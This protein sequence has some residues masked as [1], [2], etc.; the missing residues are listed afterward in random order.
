MM[1]NS[2]IQMI[3]ELSLRLMSIAID[4]CCRMVPAPRNAGVTTA[5]VEQ[6]TEHVLRTADRIA[7]MESGLVRCK[8]S[9]A[10]AARDGA[11]MDACLGA[12]E[13]RV[14]EAETCIPTLC[15]RQDH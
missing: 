1:P 2:A 8:G 9:G 12:V 10:E 13:G 7:V 11:V 5:T 14:L 15:R 3:D 4:E 6:S